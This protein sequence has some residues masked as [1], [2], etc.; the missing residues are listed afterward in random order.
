MISSDGIRGYNDAIILTVL[1]DGD[2]YGYRIAQRITQR[3][4]GAY[5]IRETTLYS[6]FTRLT[7]AGYITAYPGE[8]SY[9]R[10]R[11][12]YHLTAA[13]A[14]FLAGKKTEWVQVQ[15]VVNQFLA[16]EQ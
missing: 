4:A 9:G 7:K 15:R 1:Q 14:A 13:G 6:A 10:P 11:T 12:Y 16:E 5:E 3:T 2:S 8:I